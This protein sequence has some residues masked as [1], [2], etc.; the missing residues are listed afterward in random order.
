MVTYRP[1]KKWL[2]PLLSIIIGLAIGYTVFPSEQQHRLQVWEKALDIYEN[3]NYAIETVYSR[4]DQLYSSSKGTWTNNRASYDV[5]TPVSD[6]TNFNFTVYFMEDK[7]YVNSGEEWVYGER[8]HRLI[9]EF[10]PLDQP[11]T[12]VR[13]LLKNA[14]EIMIEKADFAVIYRAYFKNFNDIEFR[15]VRLEE[16]KNTTLEMTIFNGQLDTIELDAEP[17]RPKTVGPLVSYP[18]KL[19]YRLEFKSSDITNLELPADANTSKELE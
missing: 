2:L 4:D 17:I 3:D 7:I 19:I 10:I 16:Q 11:F 14:D 6:D 8:P 9:Q 5:S 1:I 12:W 15:G 13:D 18:E